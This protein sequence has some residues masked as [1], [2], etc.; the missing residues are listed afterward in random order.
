MSM[1]ENAQD[2]VKTGMD[3]MADAAKS[4]QGRMEIPEAARDFVKRQADQARE[5]AAE[6]HAGSSKAT[7]AMEN[8]ATKTVSGL[9]KLSREWQIAAYED[10]AA[11]F[12]TVG[13]IAG[14]KSVEEAFQVQVDYVRERSEAN[15]A[16]MRTAMSAMTE[17]VTDGV[18]KAQANVSSFVSKVGKAA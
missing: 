17:T 6:M 15:L 7:D 14:A 4:V 10:A 16:R 18:Q 13:K 2:A 3:R 11:L 12:N 9:A 1:V 5:R 8:V